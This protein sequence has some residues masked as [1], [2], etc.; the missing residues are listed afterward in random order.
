MTF[1][2]LIYQERVDHLLKL[3]HRYDIS[4]PISRSC[5]HGLV[6]EQHNFTGPRFES[7]FKTASAVVANFEFMTNSHMM[8]RVE[9]I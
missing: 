1:F 8:N 5:F 7:C 9:S 4:L 2:Q 6:G 3:D